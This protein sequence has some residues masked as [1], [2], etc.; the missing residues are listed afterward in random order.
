LLQNFFAEGSSLTFVVFL[1]FCIMIRLNSN[2]LISE[3][4]LTFKFSRSAGPG[5]QNVNKVNSRVT[6]FFDVAGSSELSENQKS[7]ILKRLGR[8]V[9]KNGILRVISQKY[10]TQTANRKETVRRLEE[11]LKDALKK[12][13]V[14]KKT[15]V[16]LK[17]KLKRREEKRRRSAL[18]QE[19][20]KSDF[21]DDSRF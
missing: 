9:D 5:G 15:I 1:G 10:R 12:K 3:D 8:R 17:E 2:T 18:K 20:A 6:L 16:P 7:R 21:T 4:R 11:L 13:P 14:R 19:R